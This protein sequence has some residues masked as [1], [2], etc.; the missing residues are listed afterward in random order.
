[1]GKAKGRSQIERGLVRLG[2]AAPPPP[3]PWRHPPCGD[4][5]TD[6]YELPLDD[7]NTNVLKVREV[8]HGKLLVDFAITHRTLEDGVWTT[9]ARVDCCHGEFHR[10]LYGRGEKDLNRLS[11]RPILSPEDVGLAYD[12]ATEFMYEDYREHLRR[13]RVGAQ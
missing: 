6:R 2:L 3:E 5:H 12:R 9:V 4:C 7:A 13:W 1:M 8:W 10:H 11:L